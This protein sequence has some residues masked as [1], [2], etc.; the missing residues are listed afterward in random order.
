MK[1]ER[2]YMCPGGKEAMI[3]LVF[4]TCVPLSFSVSINLMRASDNSKVKTGTWRVRERYI[5][6][7]K[8]CGRAKGNVEA[9]RKF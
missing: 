8:D 3:D 2:E 4:F 9:Y 5:F 1:I 7:K 6:A